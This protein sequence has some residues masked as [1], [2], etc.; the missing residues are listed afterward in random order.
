VTLAR[1]ISGLELPPSIYYDNTFE[2]S[3]KDP[4][5]DEDCEKNAPVVLASQALLRDATTES[6]KEIDRGVESMDLEY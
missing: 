2:K 6:V 3:K 4:A 5:E 1:N